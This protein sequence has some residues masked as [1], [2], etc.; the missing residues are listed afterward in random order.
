MAKVPPDVKCDWWVFNSRSCAVE[1]RGKRAIAEVRHCDRLC[2]G[3]VWEV[4]ESGPPLSWSTKLNENTYQLHVTGWG[5]QES[6][7]DPRRIHQCKEAGAL[8]VIHFYFSHPAFCLPPLIL[9]FLSSVSHV[10]P[11]CLGDTPPLSSD[12]M[13]KH[14]RGSVE[15][16]RNMSGKRAVNKVGGIFLPPVSVKDCEAPRR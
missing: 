11:V 10:L 16:M 7:F 12:R 6:T 3:N 2:F 8:V 13:W 5:R 9:H 15:L 4:S 14:A 1:P